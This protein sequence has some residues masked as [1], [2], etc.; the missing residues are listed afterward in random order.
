[1]TKYSPVIGIEIHV[2]L[3]TL[4][5]MFCGCPANHFE[6]PPNSQTCPVCLGLP[7]ALP[8]PN[9]QAIYWTVQLGLALGCQIP[10]QAKFDRKHYFYPD[11][12]KGYQIS[13]YDEPFALDGCIQTSRGEVAIER[14]HLEEDTGKLKHSIVNGK[15][16]SLIDFNRSGVPLVEIVTK[17]VIQDAHHAVEYAKQI[18]RLVR[19]LQISDADMEKGSMR[20][21]ANISL[22]QT[23]SSDLPA[24]KVEVK[25]INSFRYLKQAIEYEISRQSQLLDSG[26]IPAQET[27]GWNERKS[28]SIAQRSKE[29]AKDYRYFPEPDIPPIIWSSKDLDNLK[30]QLPPLPEAYQAKF[31]T[32]GIRSDYITTLTQTP[33]TAKWADEICSLAQ[34]QNIAI[35]DMINYIVNQAIDHTTSPNQVITRY[36]KATT[37]KSAT[38]DQINLWAQQVV[39][40]NPDIVAKYRQ[41]KT[42]VIGAL[43]GQVMRQSKGS[44]D[45]NQTKAVLIEQLKEK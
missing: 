3:R 11:L 43:I 7:G 40:A 32:L 12:P 45:P 2:E 18:S 22:R 14:A 27:R 25:N 37:K 20:L 21:E 33:Q 16:V 28:K 39:A 26:E 35:A 10:L 8:V 31:Q 1:M 36:V 19:F 5:K 6:A 42:S 38:D 15:K 41:G 24:Y 17:P 23:N 9:Q 34:Q 29:S 4:S 30:S 44:A 13:Q